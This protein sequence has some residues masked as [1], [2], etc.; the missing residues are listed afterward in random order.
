MQYEN[1]CDTQLA[2]LSNT[3]D[4]LAEETLFRRY[5]N[6][7]KKTVRPYFIIGADREDL[8]QEGMIGLYKAIRAFESA[9]DS[10]FSAFA[11]RCIK[12]QILTAVQSASRKRHSPL[13]TYISIDERLPDEDCNPEKILIFREGKSNL[14]NFVSTSLSPLESRILLYYLQGHTYAE[15][16]EKT[17]RGTKSVDNALFRIRNKIKPLT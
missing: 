10:Q 14:E 5:K 4:N 2:A 8:I 7:V 15:I 12:N 1:L 9:R 6:L 17:G 3:G 11:A 16:G 13:N